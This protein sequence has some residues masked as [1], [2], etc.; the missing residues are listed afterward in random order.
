MP[1]SVGGLERKAKP[2]EY[3]VKVERLTKE[4]IGPKHAKMSLSGR[5]ECAASIIRGAEG[6]KGIDLS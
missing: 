1:R 4:K 3:V 6:E 5:L 2:E